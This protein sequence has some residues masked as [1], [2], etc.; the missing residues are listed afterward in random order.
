MSGR[1]ILLTVLAYIQNSAENSD[2]DIMTI[3]GL[4]TDWELGQHIKA[5]A[6]LIS[7]DRQCGAFALLKAT[8]A[9]QKFME[10]E[11]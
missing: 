5:E 4:M 6:A 11:Q 9:Q 1:Q 3:A 7:H 2:R 8:V 10:M